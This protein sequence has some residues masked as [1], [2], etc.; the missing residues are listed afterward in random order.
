MHDDVRPS[1]YY[2][3][4]NGRRGLIKQGAKQANVTKEKHI[5]SIWFEE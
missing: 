3:L 5:R 4:F 1:S 2:T